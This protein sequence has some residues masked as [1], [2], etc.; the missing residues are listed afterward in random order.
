MIFLDASAIVAMLTGEDDADTLADRLALDPERRTSA[1]AVFETVAAIMRKQ[2]MGMGP[3]RDIVDRFLAIADVQLTPIGASECG[4]AL[5][6]FDRFGKG[7]NRAD[8]NM[9]DCFAYASARALGAGL[10]FKGEDFSQT[11]I[12]IA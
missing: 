9:G 8:L 4:L 11:D 1:I 7:R 3:A 5:E 6:A 2:V 10:L 12:A